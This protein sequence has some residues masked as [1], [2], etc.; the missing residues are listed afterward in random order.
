MNVNFLQLGGIRTRY[1]LKKN[2]IEKW[3]P[4]ILVFFFLLPTF[5]CMVMGS[6][7]LS[8]ASLDKRRRSPL[9]RLTSITVLFIICRYGWDTTIHVLVTDLPNVL[10]LYERKPGENPYMHKDDMQFLL[11][12]IHFCVKQVHRNLFT[13][14]D[15]LFNN[16]KQ[17]SKHGGK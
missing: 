10:L 15:W 5:Q 14:Q 8:P 1:G 17:I 7:C 9:D 11:N 4:L 12:F 13:L 2:C 3:Q 6:L 16:N